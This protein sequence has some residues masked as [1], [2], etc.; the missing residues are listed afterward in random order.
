MK[1]VYQ[2]LTVMLVIAS[3]VLSG[4]GNAELPD[5]EFSLG[6]V[7]GNTYTNEYAG[8]SLQLGA[9]WQ[10]LGAEDLQGLPENIR[11]QLKGSD[12]EQIMEDYSGILDMQ[13]SNLMTGASVNVNFNAISK[14]ERVAYALMSEEESLDVVLKQYDMLV[15]AYAQ[16]GVENAVI[17]KVTVNFL[18]EEHTALLTT[19]QVQGMDIYLVQVQ[20]Y[21]LGVY[22]VTVT[23]TSLLENTTQDI[24]D[25]FQTLQ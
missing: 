23:A 20:N 12:A 18:G 22:G 19:G 16:M 11:E 13:A 4:C 2:I 7:S 24:L 3:L 1:R 14:S 9:E 5:R 17:E 10:M 6:V 15:D 21:K 25:Q 8:V